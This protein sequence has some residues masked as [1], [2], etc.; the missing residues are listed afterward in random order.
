[1]GVC[2]C[3]GRCGR[4]GYR[5]TVLSCPLHLRGLKRLPKHMA[6][7]NSSP[8]SNRG[9][10]VHASTPMTGFFLGLG[11]PLQSHDSFWGVI[12]DELGEM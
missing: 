10:G 7:V 1:M 12:L 6:C 9:Q 3:V 5:G 2:L 8:S 11:N 4:L